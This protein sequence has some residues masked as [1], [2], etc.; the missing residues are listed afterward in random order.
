MCKRTKDVQGN[1]SLEYHS[2]PGPD[3]TATVFTMH[4]LLKVKTVLTFDHK[5]APNNPQIK[6]NAMNLNE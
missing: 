3:R 6:N 5:R 4:V 2:T 1:N